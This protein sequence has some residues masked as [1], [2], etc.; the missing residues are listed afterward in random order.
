MTDTTDTPTLQN[1]SF[2]N[3]ASQY[4]FNET[5]WSNSFLY[6]DGNFKTSVSAYSN[7]IDLIGVNSVNLYYVPDLSK[8]FMYEQIKLDKTVLDLTI[9]SLDTSFYFDLSAQIDNTDIRFRA[10]QMNRYEFIVI[11]YID[12]DYISDINLTANWDSGNEFIDTYIIT[13]MLLSESN[14]AF[15][16]SHRFR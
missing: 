11:F 12:C 14:I 13:K 3:V 6:C 4:M 5:L 9:N 16:F 15:K 2:I 8:I 1:T 10:M 7:Y